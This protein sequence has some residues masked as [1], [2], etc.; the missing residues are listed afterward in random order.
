[1]Y[2][3]RQ[4]FPW[5]PRFTHLSRQQKTLLSCIAG[6][7]YCAATEFAVPRPA[8]VLRCGRRWGRG[9]GRSGGRRRASRYTDGPA[10]GRARKG[11]PGWGWP[12]LHASPCVR[13]A[14]KPRGWDKR[15][16]AW[17]TS[18]ARRTKTTSSGTW[19]H[20][21]GATPTSG[22]YHRGFQGSIAGP[23]FRG[24]LPS[25]VSWELP[26]VWGVPGA[27]GSAVRV[28]VSPQAGPR[29]GHPIAAPPGPPSEPAPLAARPGPAEGCGQ[30]RGPPGCGGPR[31][32]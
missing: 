31:A 15:S 13:R 16:P 3:S 11:V 23:G 26:G 30:G 14:L 5:A 1:M 20:S 12:A 25:E 29:A 9:G 7:E 21:S 10:A 24:L 4:D 18:W 2:E 6:R 22:L 28:C 17:L 19:R 27:A 32:L 8:S